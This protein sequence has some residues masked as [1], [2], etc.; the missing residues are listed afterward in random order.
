M[1]LRNTFFSLV[2]LVALGV[3]GV[4]V[5]GSFGTGIATADSPSPAAAANAAKAGG[6]A[7]EADDAKENE[8]ENEADD[9]AEAGDN[10]AAD[11]NESGD[12]EGDEAGDTDN[13]QDE[14]GDDTADP[15][16]QAALA[17]RATVT[18]EAAV[19]AASAK[20][21]GKAVKTEIEDEKGV[22]KYTIEFDSGQEVEIDAMTGAV[23]TVSATD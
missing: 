17:K 6:A 7:V 20:V 23:L 14:Q 3:A 11:A 21:P 13:V 2:L 9:P 10:D 1:D 18:T 5:A 4:L 12:H 22:L 19:A 8:S 15:A 16:E